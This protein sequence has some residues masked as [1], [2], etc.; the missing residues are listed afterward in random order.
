MDTIAVRLT[1][2]QMEVFHAIVVAAQ[3]FQH[4]PDLL[5]R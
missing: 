5:L 3:P 4:D 1:V 2:K